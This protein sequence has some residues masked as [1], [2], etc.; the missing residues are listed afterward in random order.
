M[1]KLSAALVAG[2]CLAATGSATGSAA[3]E[4]V[5]QQVVPLPESVTK[6]QFPNWTADGSRILAA[7]NSTDFDGTQLVTF[8]PNGSA[9]RCLTC[10]SWT[11][12]ELLKMFPFS[13]G[14]R[15]LVRI[16]RQSPI[17]AADHGIVECTPSVL[18]CRKATVMPIV[19][20]S[21][22]DSNVVQDQREF[23]VAPDGTHVAFTQ[24]RLTA[25][26][27]AVG[28]GVVGRLV[29]G[30][31][32]Y[33]VA[34]AR[35]VAVDGELKNFTP[36]GREVLFARFLGGFEAGNPDDVGVDLRSG[37][38]RRVTYALDWDEDVDQSPQR[39]QGRNWLVVGSARGTGLLETLS[40]VRRPTAIETGL[41][42]LPFAVF[43]SQ[44][45][46]IAEPWIVARGADRNGR[47]GQPLAPGA[48]AAGWNSRP[49]FSWNPDGNAIV[50]WQFGTTDRERTRVVVARLPARRPQARARAQ[51]TPSPRWA[52]RLAG[53]V[54]P[55]P[56]LPSSRKGRIAGRMSVT[57]GRS[58]VPGRQLFI[59]V[60]YR[61]FSDRP[62]FVIDG[63][64]RS[65][66][67][68]PALY[69]GP[70][71]YSADLVVSGR[72]TGFLRAANVGITNGSIDG[73]IESM[74]D[75]RRLSLGPLG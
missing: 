28:V 14:R 10:G 72:H 33:R 55:D 47:L 7:A 52:P 71:V 65:D 19:P 53:Y 15:I 51:S 50:F 11:G 5:V 6:V 40:Q 20:P 73:R 41:S 3:A 48:A 68:P 46:G 49:N 13:D 21:A 9:L 57:V 36:D 59:E 2:G 69:G 18:K 30:R 31:S 66:Y 43:A 67:D 63:V 75:G 37:Q 42:A 26:G 45:G 60:A 29:R 24:P 17:A 56:R 12:P 1:R 58:P 38:E 25:S 34:D 27:Q 8:A 35:V 4:P 22:G 64:E 39:F 44:T 23:R 62:G 54:P 32:A 70:S 74:V 61:H 16:G